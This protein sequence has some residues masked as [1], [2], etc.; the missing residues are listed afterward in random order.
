MVRCRARHCHR[1]HSHGVQS[2]RRHSSRCLRSE[3]ETLVKVSADR[4]VL[5]VSGY[6]LSYA[7]PEGEAKAL[8]DVSLDIRRGET[9]ALVGE[10]GS[11]K[12]TLAWAIMRYLP[13]NARDPAG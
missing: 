9:H 12:S 13:T 1:Y 2:L 8:D 10:S 11:G 5:D 7:T 3:K 4:P 6:S